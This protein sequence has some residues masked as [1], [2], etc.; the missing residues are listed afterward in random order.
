MKGI[1]ALLM[2][3]IMMAAMIAPAMSENAETSANVGN[4]A[5][6]VCAKWE[7]P[8]DDTTTP[9]TQVMPNAC[10][11]N[12]TVTIYACVSD[13]NGND[14]IASVT[15]AVTGP[16]ASPPTWNVDLA[17]NTSMDASCDAGCIGYSGTFDMACSDPA[18]LYTVVVTVT[19]ASASTG[20]NENTFDYLSVISMTAG[21]VSFGD[22]AP[23]ES[24]T[25]S[26]LVTC[27]GNAEIEFVDAT[28]ANYD[29]PDDNDGISWTN[30]TN[31]ASDIIDDGQITTTWAPATTITCGNTDNVPFTLSVP[32]GTASG[33]YTGTVVFTPTA[34]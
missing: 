15:A 28:P 13:G 22:V 23:G 26:S 8:D 24:S 18:G 30:M 14:D 29:N 10:P 33:L 9:G 19:D 5:P 32:A 7:E 17:R 20:T 21:D 34:V 2:A 6:V 25:A 27:T 4:I 31:A 1:L 11:G 3:S 12:K 16:G